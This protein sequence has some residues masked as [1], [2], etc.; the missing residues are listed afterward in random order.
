MIEVLRNKYGEF[1]SK[2]NQSMGLMFCFF[3]VLFVQDTEKYLG[4]EAEIYLA[5]Q[6]ICLCFQTAETI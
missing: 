3:H 4:F 5:V 2:L 1:Q 6:S